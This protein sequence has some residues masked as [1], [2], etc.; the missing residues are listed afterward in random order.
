MCHFN[1]LLIKKNRLKSDF[2]CHFFYM[3]SGSHYVLFYLHTRIPSFNVSFFHRRI[4]LSKN[5][6]VAVLQ[7]E[8]TRS[9]RCASA[10]LNTDVGAV[11]APNFSAS[12]N[13]SASVNTDWIFSVFSVKSVSVKSVCQWHRWQ[14]SQCST[15][16]TVGVVGAQ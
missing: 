10:P 8:S 1:R 5:V 12:L 13:F 3:G 2:F 4:L 9:C 11:S 6:T 14:C 16:H 15:E 7:L